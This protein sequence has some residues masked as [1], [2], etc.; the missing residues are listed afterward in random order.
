VAKVKVRKSS[1][2]TTVFEL[3]QSTEAA[4]MKNKDNSKNNKV[5]DRLTTMVGML[6]S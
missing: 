5:A 6:S 2:W 4:T 3:F 1:W